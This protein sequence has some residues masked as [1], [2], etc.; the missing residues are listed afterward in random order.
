[1]PWRR[2]GGGVV[3]D[4]APLGAG[5]G[6]VRVD[7]VGVPAPQGSK[8][9][10]GR[11]ILIED[12]RRVGPWRDAVTAAVLAAAPPMFYGPVAVDL[13]FRLLRPRSVTAKR[14]QW[15]SVR[16]DLD[17]LTRST[18]DGLVT[19][20]LLVDDAIVCVLVVMKTYCDAGEPPGCTVIVEAM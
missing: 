8:R 9:H 1:M 16:P 5:P 13:G 14:R 15:P 4:L 19:G 10:V 17:K 3:N 20:R 2:A 18:L 7:I 11:G 6:A 12:S